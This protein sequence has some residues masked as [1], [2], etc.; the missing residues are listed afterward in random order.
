M[1]EGNLRL[2]KTENVPLGLVGA[3]LFSLIGG[4]LWFILYQLGFLVELSGIVL[5][6]C[7]YRGYVIFS[8]GSNP[9][10]LIA[11]VL[12]SLFVLLAAWFLSINLD[13]YE[14]HVKW[15][16]EG[17][18]DA[19]ISYVDA[20]EITPRYLVDDDL[21]M[22]YLKPLIGGV[23]LSLIV[24]ILPI[25]N[26]FTRT[27]LEKRAKHAKKHDIAASTRPANAEK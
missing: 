12:I 13:V 5:S 21:T 17:V 20:L 24:W 9:I 6:L 22:Y 11:S 19:P 3:F 25:K 15:Y 14:D 27:I 1:N 23:I 16:I 26:A 8:K 18:L 7:A 2:E 4:T 10:G